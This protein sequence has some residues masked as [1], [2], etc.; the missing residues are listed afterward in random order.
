MAKHGPPDE[1][2]PGRLARLSSNFTLA[3]PKALE[4]SEFD[5]K[6]VI[7]LT[8][9]GEKLSRA[10]VKIWKELAKPPVELPLAVRK[11][12]VDGRPIVNTDE[13]VLALKTIHPDRIILKAVDRFLSGHEVRAQLLK[14]D[15]ILLDHAVMD[16]LMAN[17][18]HIPEEM[19]E[20]YGAGTVKVFFDGVTIRD[21]YSAERSFFMSYHPTRDRWESDD[22]LLDRRRGPGDYVAVLPL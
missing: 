22:C 18:K 16:S 15:V 2:T 8:G 19:S 14:Q 20:R 21:T 10:M 4:L 7:S 5:I 13:R 17:P 1:V 9:E 3:L 6:D 11:Q 12:N